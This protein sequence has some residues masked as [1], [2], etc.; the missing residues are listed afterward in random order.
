MGVNIDLK[1]KKILYN[2]SMDG[3]MSYTQLGKKVGLSKNAVKYRIERLKKEGVINKVT[4]VVNLGVLGLNTCVVLFRFNDDLKEN[5]DIIE[6]FKNHEFSGWVTT[7]SGEWD[8]LSELVYRDMNHLNEIL[9]RIRA[10]FGETLSMIKPLFSHD[11]LQVENTVRSFFDEEIPKKKRVREKAEFNKKDR[12]ILNLLSIDSSQSFVDI[13]SVMDMSADAIVYRVNNLIK[14]GAIVKFFPRIPMKKIG[15]FEY[16]FVIKMKNL[17]N[18]VKEKIE[19]ALGNHKNVT[20]SFFDPLSMSY[21]FVFGF[22]SVEEIDSLTRG[23]RKEYRNYIEEQN[24]HM[25]G[26]E[27]VYNLFP[28]GLINN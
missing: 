26:E 17:D 25:I 13:A 28:A 1:D 8:V 19:N 15:Y 11:A 22:R 2:L 6:F 27:I 12:K 18:K 3:R 23:F 10:Y 7:M 16:L 5:K 20:Y 14:K 9:G 4:C 24:Y 21:V